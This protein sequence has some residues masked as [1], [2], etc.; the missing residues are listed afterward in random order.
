MP[1]DYNP[2]AL[3]ADTE[4]LDVLIVDVNGVLRGKPDGTLRV[5]YIPQGAFF[6][7]GETVL[8]SGLGG[9]FPKGIPLGQIIATGGR[10]IDVFQW[11]VVEPTVDFRRL[12]LAMVVTN[13]D[14]L[15]RVPELTVPS[16]EIPE[17]V[18]EEEV[19]QPADSQP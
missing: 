12:E 11:A 16:E 14:P 15:E 9:R 18:P 19:E 1:N 4:L 8:S 10:D 5:D 2:K 17:E 7:A 6:E 3:A 13:F